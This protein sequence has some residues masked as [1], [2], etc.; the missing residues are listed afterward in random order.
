MISRAQVAEY[1]A[2]K[3]DTDRH[4]AVREAAAWLVDQKRGNEVR[5]LANDVAR[6]LEAKGY[7]YARI[8]TAKKL[9]EA[10]SHEVQTYVSHQTG[11]QHVEVTEAVDETLIGG[12]RIETPE[13][14][15]D[16]TVAH[17]LAKFV[18]AEGVN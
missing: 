6:A 5:Y 13:R 14:E 3:L 2:G 1:I 9:S 8:T 7:T 10:A 16:A 12:V 4:E 11:A 18:E 15:L 17:K